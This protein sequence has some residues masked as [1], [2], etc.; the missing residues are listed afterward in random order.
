MTKVLT[1]AALRAPLPSVDFGAAGIHEV[2]HISGTAMQLVQSA[3]TESSGVALWEAAAL[4]VPTAARDAV[5]AL[6]LAEVQA[7]IGIASGSAEAVLAQVGN[8]GAPASG[9]TPALVP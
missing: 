4:C 1:L 9:D 5:F 8:A 7:I 2:Q 3:Q 6:G